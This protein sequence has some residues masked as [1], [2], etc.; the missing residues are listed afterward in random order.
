M[1]TFTVEKEF[2][3]AP[4]KYYVVQ[5]DGGRVGDEWDGEIVEIVTGYTV[6][7][8]DESGMQEDTEFF[9]VVTNTQTM[10]NNE[11]RVLRVIRN[12]YNAGEYENYDW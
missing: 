8:Y 3:Q 5:S 11:E 1:K 9:P 7:I 10:E 12:K 2:L 4:R 6:H